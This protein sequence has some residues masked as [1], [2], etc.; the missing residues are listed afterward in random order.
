MRPR[1]PPEITTPL[2]QIRALIV[3]MDADDGDDD[4]DG[5]L[6]NMASS[7]RAEA[8]VVPFAEDMNAD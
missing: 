4:D 7:N 8:I 5:A 6:F 1:V 3:V 2:D